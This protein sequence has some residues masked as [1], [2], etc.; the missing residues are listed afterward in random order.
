MIII[1]F[2][3]LW[4]EIESVFSTFL[5]TIFIFEKIPDFKLWRLWR[6]Q[7]ISFLAKKIYLALDFECTKKCLTDDNF[8]VFFD[9]WDNFFL[10]DDH[11]FQMIFSCLF[12]KFTWIKCKKMQNS[13]FES[14]GNFV[15]NYHLS[16][17]L[18]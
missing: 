4:I 3:T 17:I 16:K 11:Q 2:K 8:L 7:K 10:I 5:N 18:E 1:F 12:V 9:E 15:K 6:V 14:K 13:N